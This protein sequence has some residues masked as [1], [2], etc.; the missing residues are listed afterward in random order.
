MVN[1]FV[2]RDSSLDKAWGLGI[3]VHRSPRTPYSDSELL[4]TVYVAWSLEMWFMGM[5]IFLS[6]FWS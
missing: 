5:Q 1:V 4:Q 6:M 2:D 3:F